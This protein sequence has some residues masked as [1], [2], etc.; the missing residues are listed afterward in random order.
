MDPNELFGLSGG[1]PPPWLLDTPSSND[2]NGVAGDDAAWVDPLYRLNV[3][4][5]RVGGR[6]V[7]RQEISIPP[8]KQETPI[9]TFTHPSH[10]EL[11]ALAG[12]D[13]TWAGPLY[14]QGLDD[15]AG[16]DAEWVEPLYRQWVLQTR[17][18]P[19]EEIPIP[20][21]T[22]EELIAHKNGG[23]TSKVLVI[24]GAILW[25]VVLGGLL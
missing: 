17:E 21:L 4:Q 24:L 19:R 18:A 3:I 11:F 5:A 25:V 2:V 10:E 9:P 8:L 1:L 12:C 14:R 15:L 20:R 23:R 6:P 22:H 7:A 13:A 16:D